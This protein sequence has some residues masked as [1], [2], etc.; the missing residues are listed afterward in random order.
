MNETE[1]VN[2]Q[3]KKMANKIN[4][5]PTP[6]INKK[7]MSQI[8]EKRDENNHKLMMDILNNHLDEAEKN[9]D[10]KKMF[11]CISNKKYE[12]DLYEAR[13][14]FRSNT[15]KAEQIIKTVSIEKRNLFEFLIR[16][17]V[18][19]FW[20]YYKEKTN[21]EVDPIKIQKY[22]NEIWNINPALYRKLQD[23]YT[24]LKKIEEDRKIIDGTNNRPRC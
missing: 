17:N 24:L 1:L 11:I 7:K 19:E 16:N 12:T 22:Y 21:C 14:R 13:K 23:Y 9:N 3:R 18:N 20:E 2:D 8:T 6:I 15:D 4:N 5:I 10:G